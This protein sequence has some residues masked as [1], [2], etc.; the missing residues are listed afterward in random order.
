VSG[1][2]VDVVILDSGTL[3]PNHPEFAVNA[4]GS[5]GSRAV[6]FNWFIY[7][8]WLNLGTNGQYSD[9]SY[10]TYDANHAAHCAGIA[11][12]NTYG[13]ARSANIYSINY[14][15]CPG[16]N[17]AT[18]FANA[19]DYI[20]AFHVNK[21]VNPATNR[22]NPT[23]I[24]CSDYWQ[25]YENSY[26]NIV[27]VNYRGT[28]HNAPAGGFTQSQLATLGILD[29][30]GNRTIYVD[31]R[32]ATVDAAVARCIAA[33]VTVVSI[34][35]NYGSYIDLPSGPDYNNYFIDNTGAVVFYHQGS[36][37]GAAPGVICVGN[38]NSTVV[39]Q[40]ATDSGNGPRVD[41]FAPGTSIISSLN[42]S[43]G[44]TQLSTIN[45]VTGNYNLPTV[46]DP[47]N[48][49]FYVGKDSGTSMACPQVAGYLACM[50]EKYPTATPT[51]LYS[52][53]ANNASTGQ[54]T[55]N[56]AGYGL[57]NDLNG[58]SNLV[59]RAAFT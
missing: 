16:G 14:T 33:G 55:S 27:T 50:L 9:T 8:E 6:T 49:A 13:W 59:L 25:H 24:S 21:P 11:A 38:M 48:P 5:G 46:Q 2:N 23:I 34:A 39:E 10:N 28:T 22:K 44:A 15:V 30:I 42:T 29:P 56:V 57:N 54:L 41:V 19:F 7:N 47:R 4:N 58:A 37:P 43:I 1:K 35:G 52:F 51:Q 3:N 26:T 45:A 20:R 18:G 32:N 53:V 12:G 36:S 31:Q 40:K 17:S